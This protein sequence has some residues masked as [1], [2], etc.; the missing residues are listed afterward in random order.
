MNKYLLPVF[1][2]LIAVIIS[3]LIFIQPAPFTLFDF[4]NYDK[5][6]TAISG[7]TA[8]AI[9][10]VSA[11]L[12]Y[13]ALMEQVKVTR[14]QGKFLEL[15]FEANKSQQEQM[16]IDMLHNL[17]FQTEKFIEQF[18]FSF[19]RTRT[20]TENSEKKVTKDDFRFTGIEAIHR[21]CNHMKGVR[22]NGGLNAFYQSS[23]LVLITR[24]LLQLEEEVGKSN[25]QLPVKKQFAERVNML[26]LIVQDPL[27]ELLKALDNGRIGEDDISMEIRSFM[28][29]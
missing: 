11:I 27:K 4:S 29:K 13:M 1:I 15:Q 16:Q 20:T 2:V 7:L 19:E 18:F 23:L 22:Y 14:Q 24:S 10:L 17:T 28:I 5:L 25:I 12:L 21:W 26:K 8:P 6:G 9:G 3:A